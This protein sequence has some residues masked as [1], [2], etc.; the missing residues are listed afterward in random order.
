MING[1]PM[2]CNQQIILYFLL[3]LGYWELTDSVYL[4]F[5]VVLEYLYFYE[6]KEYGGTPPPKWQ[7]KQKEGEGET[8]C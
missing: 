1:T 6:S 2:S 5:C 7:R 8:P 4:G 3:P